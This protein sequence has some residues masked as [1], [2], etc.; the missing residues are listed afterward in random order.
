MTRRLLLLF[1]VLFLLPLSAHAVWWMSQDRADSWSRADWSS[2]GLLP[3]A[4]ARPQ[5]MVHVYGARVGRWRGIFAHHTWIVLKE[6][7]ASRYSRYDVVGWGSPVRQDIRAPDGRWYGNPPELIASLE[8]DAAQALIPK[9][10][11]AIASYPHRDYGTYRAWPGPNSNTFV[12]HV[13]A[14]VPEWP[15]AL[16]PTAIGKDFRD[17]GLYAGLTPSGTGFQL[18]ALGVAALSVGWVEGLEVNLLGLVAGLDLRQ[19]ALKLPGFG[20]IGLNRIGLGSE[21]AAGSN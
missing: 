8:G 7:G 12:A 14:Q 15:V 13:L 17:D 21:A 19:P 6:E 3:P 10:R 20:R 9:L 1:L 16:P 11:A 2:A 18:S 5:A 4:S